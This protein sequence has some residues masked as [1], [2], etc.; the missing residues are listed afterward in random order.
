[1]PVRW[2]PQPQPIAYR[3]LY[4]KWAPQRMVESQTMSKYRDRAYKHEAPEGFLAPPVKLNPTLYSVAEIRQR[5]RME[6]EARYTPEALKAIRAARKLR[7]LKKA[8]QSRDIR[9]P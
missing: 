3:L 9:K 1:M 7:W 6:E 4:V 5:A 2:L 8:K